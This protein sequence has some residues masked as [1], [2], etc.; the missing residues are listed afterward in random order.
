MKVDQYHTKKR[1]LNGVIKHESRLIPH[2]K[3]FMSHES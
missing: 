3:V 1:L 2:E